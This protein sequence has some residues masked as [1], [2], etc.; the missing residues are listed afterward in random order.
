MERFRAAR[1]M[2]CDY[3]LAQLHAD[4]SFGDPGAGLAGYFFS[5]AAL[6]VGGYTE[7]ANRLCHWI[8]GHGLL[9]SGDF[10]PRPAHAIGY[11]YAYY[12]SWVIVGAHRLG[13]FDLSQRGMDF[14]MDFWDSESGGF[15]SSPT[16]RS[17]QT[18]QDL[19]VVAGCGRAALYTGR[20]EVARGVGR[21]MK[22]LMEAQPSY[23]QRLF[24]VYSRAEGLHTVPDPA[25]EI[26]YVMSHDAE[27]DQFFFHPGIAGGY[28]ARLY[29]A[30]GETEWLELA[31][32]YMR[33]A[34]GA[35]DYLFSLLRAGKVGWA[36]SL[37]W[38]LTG[39][40]K[41]QEMAIR[42]GDNLVAAQADDGWWAGLGDDVNPSNTTT[43][44][45]TI[46]L[47]EIH[48]AVGRG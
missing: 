27:R 2:G 3:L 19:W 12:N 38:T 5:P 34:E 18:K 28:L 20:M 26:R 10:G 8:R 15:Y 6:A 35:S 33:F 22:T 43:A 37:L 24:S 44:E 42:V 1:D 11:A 36:A 47:D 30:T 16:Q 39:E 29:Q 40:Q 14:L 21:W 25:D 23:P 32:E 45:M 4:G 46:W 48:Q 17:A 31:K 13:Q 7:A 41:Y 9:A